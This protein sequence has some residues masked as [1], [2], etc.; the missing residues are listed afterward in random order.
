MDLRKLLEIVNLEDLDDYDSLDDDN[1]PG[2]FISN[3]DNDSLYLIDNR[4]NKSIS[5]VFSF[6]MLKEVNTS[7]HNKIDDYL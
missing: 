7:Y 5:K 1:L 4:D 3:R 2:L 6:I